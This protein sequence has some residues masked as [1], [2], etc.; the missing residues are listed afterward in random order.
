[1]QAF[2]GIRVLDLTHVLAG[3]YASYQLALLGADVIKIESPHRPDM[4]RAVGSVPSANQKGMGADYATQAANKR[5]LALDLTAPDGQAILLD[6][7]RTADVLIENYQAGS[8][9]RLGVGYEHLR[10]INPGLIYCSVT[11]YGHTGPNAD[12]PSYDAV[13]KAASGFLAAQHRTVAAAEMVIGPSIFD[14]ATG[15]MAAFAV[16]SALFRRAK[17]GLGQCLDVSMF[18]VALSLLSV[19][20]TNLF[21]G[22]EGPGPEK[23]INQGH[24]GYRL[25]ET[26]DGVL[27]AGAWTG[28]QTSA[29]WTVLGKPDRAADA[30]GR[31]I[32]DLETAPLEVIAEAQAVL[33]TKTADEWSALLNAAQVPA[34]RV[35]SLEEAVADPQVSHRGALHTFADG[36]THTTGAFIA[37]SDGP[38]LCS[39]PPIVGQHTDEILR[40]LGRTPGEI[41][42]LRA[43]GVI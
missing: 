12:R 1:M 43:R 29:F 36:T 4:V 7:A 15:A 38:E 11:G 34:S 10:A 42:L 39:P 14:Y 31:A 32:T 28:E 33:L 18:D 5:A 25:Y 21:A 27:M 13:I 19:D 30:L 41:A 17:T 20:I 23:W 16:A 24:P 2:A 40:E 35:R 9:D 26:A 6:L 3:P 22:N 37:D 8:L